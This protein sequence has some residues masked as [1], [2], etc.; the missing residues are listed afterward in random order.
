[1][2][3]KV[4]LMFLFLFV[5]IGP[6]AYGANDNTLLSEI[7]APPEPDNDECSA[8]TEL[9]V[10]SDNLCTNTTS[11][12]VELATESSEAVVCTNKEDEANDDVWFKF[13]ATATTHKIELL[14]VVGSN[15]NLYHAIYDG[16]ASGDCTALSLVFCSDPNSSEPTGL[17][18]GNTYFIRVFTNSTVANDAT[19]DICV[20]TAPATPPANDDCANAASVGSIP[21]SS[22]V[23][24]TNA[25]N[26]T[27]F[28]DVS[29][30]G[31]MNDGVWYTI[32]G[33]GNQLTVN[34]LP[35][36]WDVELAVYTG[37]CGSFTCVTSA[38]LNPSAG[39]EEV[40]FTSSLGET[41]YIN[42]GHESDTVDQPEGIFNINITSDVLSIDDLI[43]KGFTYYPNPVRDNDLNLSAN[44][45]IRFVAVYNYLGQQLRLFAPDDLKAKIDFSGLPSG[46]YFV[47]AYVGENAAGI[48]KILKK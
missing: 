28:I 15:T 24:A 23:D 41:Y 38:N 19:F 45:T 1:M 6:Q 16:G 31:I 14:N 9:T 4:T 7:M 17:T 47:K 33:D 10:N 13:V 8:A 39:A 37:S 40:T 44:E 36:A 3:K 22:T 42:V 27:G 43:E 48:F 35:T 12:T 25:T 5:L 2:K 30:C 26:N 11:G 34:V 29:G 21:F 18:I 20:G 32:V 46:A